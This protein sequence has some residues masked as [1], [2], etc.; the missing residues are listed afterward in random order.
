MAE[1]LGFF[2]RRNFAPQFERAVSP[3][4]LRARLLSGDLLAAQLPASLPIAA[5]ST[6]T[7][8]GNGSA[9]ELVTLMI[10]SEHGLSVTLAHEL[11]DGVRFLEL[12][13]LRDAVARRPGGVTFA[14][15]VAGGT[16][17]LLLRYVLAAA[18]VPASRFRILSIPVERMIADL[19]EDRIVGFCA[20]D[21]WPALAVAQEVGLT[22][23]T[24]QDIWRW[25]PQS[26]L[27]TTARQL[28][29]NRGDLKEVLRA[30]LQ[31]SVWLDTPGNRERPLTGE[32][33]ARR[34]ALDIDAQ[35]IRAR[36]GSVYDLGCGAGERDFEDDELFFHR[37]GRVN[38]P[39]RADALLF[40]AL[41]D[42]FGL[43]RSPPKP[44][45]VASTLRDEIYREVAGEMGVAFPDDMHPFIVTLDAT[46]FDPGAP[47]EWPRLW[48][49]QPTPGGTPL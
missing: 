45:A 44:A 18:G 48:P 5:L 11:C 34:Q 46:R 15:P 17:D 19:R 23:A 49:L 2:G 35:P 40:S 7:S 20:A 9:G 26:A 21:P 32:L 16:E 6:G 1:E 30:V 33:L 43:T 38:L 29:T 22:F 27:V 14:V 10:L 3:A 28:E 39:R 37:G 31:A 8:S 24:A 41:L 42:R 4:D 36:M 25:G 12:D 13:T 47:G